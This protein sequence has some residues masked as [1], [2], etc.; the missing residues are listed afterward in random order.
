M[1]SGNAAPN[2]HTSRSASNSGAAL[3]RL[4]LHVAGHPL[5]GDMQL[6][7]ERELPRPFGFGRRVIRRALEVLEAEGLIWRQQGKGTF[8]GNRP[9]GGGAARRY[10][11]ADRSGCGDG[12]AKPSSAR[13]RRWQ[14]CAPRRQIATL[15]NARRSA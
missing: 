2:R 11:R 8:V 9:R 10:S 6:A 13:W 3:E 14:S 4:R 12:S 7:P 15:W 5:H 1:Q